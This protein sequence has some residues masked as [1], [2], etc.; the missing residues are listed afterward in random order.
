M[1]LIWV[2]GTTSFS[3]FIMWGLKEPVSHFA[4]VFDDKLVFHSDLLGV[5]V[6][7]YPTF[8]KTHEIVFQKDFPAA[9]LETEEDTYQKIITA[10]DGSGYDYKALLYFAWRGVLWRFFKR[11]FPDSNPW[12]SDKSFLCTEMAKVLPDWIIPKD[13]KDKDLGIVS[14]YKLWWMVR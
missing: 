1:K 13:V 7:W 3:K 2:K 11:P 8:L 9:T 12:G 4:I 6:A 10:F 5:R 14:P